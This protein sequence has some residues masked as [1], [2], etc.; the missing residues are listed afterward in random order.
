MRYSKGIH[1]IVPNS[2]GIHKIVPIFIGGTERSGTT[3]LGDLLNGESL[4]R[5]NSTTEI[6]FLA[7]RDGFLRDRGVF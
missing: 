7:N 6:E 3:V 1:K 5:T 2:K 4:V